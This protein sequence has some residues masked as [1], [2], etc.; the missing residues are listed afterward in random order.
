MA[1]VNRSLLRLGTTR[2]LDV[3]KPLG[4]PQLLSNAAVPSC[5]SS[6]LHFQ[7]CIAPR[8][9]HLLTACADI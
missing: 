8:R 2:A 5:P 6:L 9:L 1:A 4:T 7:R 3:P